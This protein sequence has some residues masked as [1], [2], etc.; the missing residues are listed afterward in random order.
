MPRSLTESTALLQGAN[1]ESYDTAIGGTA[2]AILFDA[3]QVELLPA[4]EF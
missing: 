4:Q 2:T 1:I 3:V